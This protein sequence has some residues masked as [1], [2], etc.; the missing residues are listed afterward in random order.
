MAFLSYHASACGGGGGGGAEH[1]DAY[2]WFV[3]APLRKVSVRQ[4]DSRWTT[5][6]MGFKGTALKV[7][8]AILVRDSMPPPIQGHFGTPVRVTSV[9]KTDYTVLIC[10]H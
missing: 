1:S 2:L 8:L 5:E 7:D 4:S 10:T 6:F 9:C 3:I